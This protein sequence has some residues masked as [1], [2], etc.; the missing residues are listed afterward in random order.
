ME[1]EELQGFVRT[2]ERKLI[3]MLIDSPD[4]YAHNALY[5]LSVL[6]GIEVKARPHPYFADTL[7]EYIEDSEGNIVLI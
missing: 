2:V 3:Q 7:Q 4:E 1:V 5:Y 6:F